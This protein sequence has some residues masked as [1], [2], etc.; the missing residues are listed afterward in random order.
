MSSSRKAR[1]GSTVILI[2]SSLAW[3]GATGLHAA[4]VR[5][6]FTNCQ[7]FIERF[8]V[9][10]NLAHDDPFL[11]YDLL[12]LSYKGSFV[13]YWIIPTCSRF[14]E[15][16]LCKISCRLHPHCWEIYVRENQTETDFRFLWVPTLT[17]LRLLTFHPRCKR[18]ITFPWPISV[19]KAPH[20][21]LFTFFSFSWFH[22]TKA[23]STNPHVLQ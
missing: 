5:F 10:V 6:I 3:L 15:C 9:T 11:I 8:Q 22:V 19:R 23:R 7:S 18:I 20:G 12:V 16:Q 21:N 4:F 13:F 14:P 2:P 1:G 17:K